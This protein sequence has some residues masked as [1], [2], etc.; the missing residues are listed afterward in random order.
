MALL[1]AAISEEKRRQLKMFCVYVISKSQLGL[2]L[3]VWINI[4]AAV[5]LWH[6]LHQFSNL[7]IIICWTD[8]SRILTLCVCVGVG[9]GVGGWD[10]SHMAEL[11]GQNGLAL[12]NEVPNE[13]SNEGSPNPLPPPPPPPA[14]T[15]TSPPQQMVFNQRE[16][17]THWGR[18]KWR[19][20]GC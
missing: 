14:I 9:E 19:N 15:P 2:I 18:D 3:N 17:H 6:W 20:E 5:Q 11:H 7:H 10:L 4:S 1:L 13:V 12:S 8:S 16:T